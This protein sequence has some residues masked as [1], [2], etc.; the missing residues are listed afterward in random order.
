VITH[1]FFHL[2]GLTD[3]PII[4]NTSDALEDANTMAQLVAYVHDRTRW[5]DSSG[6]SKPPVI[7]PAP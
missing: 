4:A 2:V 5:N 7:Y 1:E 3:R 6:L